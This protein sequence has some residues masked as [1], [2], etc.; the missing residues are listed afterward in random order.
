MLQF[1]AGCAVLTVGCGRLK[2]LVVQD[3]KML[4]INI[5]LVRGGVDERCTCFVCVNE[6]QESLELLARPRIV[7]RSAIQKVPYGSFTNQNR[8]LRTSYL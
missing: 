8:R 1:G 7:G 3:L 4:H 2:S 5:N 6:R